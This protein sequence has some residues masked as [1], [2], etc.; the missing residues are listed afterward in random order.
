MVKAFRAVSSSDLHAGRRR[1]AVHDR[2][3]LLAVGALAP[4]RAMS[5]M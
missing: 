4:L 3:Y 1:R 2:D 5:R